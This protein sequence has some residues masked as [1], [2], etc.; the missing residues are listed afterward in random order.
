MGALLS[1]ML[2]PLLPLLGPIIVGRIAFYLTEVIDRMKTVTGSWN[3]T[4]KQSL[5][6]GIAALLAALGAAVGQNFVAAGTPVADIL[7]NVDVNAI[8]GALYA[9]AIKHGQQ[10]TAAKLA[11]PSGGTVK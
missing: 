1:K 8:A 5:A 9:F 6:A 3:P 10:A 7:N 4:A 11:A 2:L